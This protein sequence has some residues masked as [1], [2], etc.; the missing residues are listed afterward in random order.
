MTSA[1]SEAGLNRESVTSASFHLSAVEADWAPQSS[2]VGISHEGKRLV[3]E[4]KGTGIFEYTGQV[5]MASEEFWSSENSPMA[6]VSG[7]PH[8][9]GESINEFDTGPY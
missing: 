8:M 5:D 9:D 2:G 4:N 7:R 6:A 1:I 3:S